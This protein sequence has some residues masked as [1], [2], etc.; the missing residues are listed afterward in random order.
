MVDFT[1]RNSVA[2]H[3]AAEDIHGAIGAHPFRVEAMERTLGD[4]WAPA[5][6]LVPLLA[7]RPAWAVPLPGRGPHLDSITFARA[8]ADLTSPP[9]D[10]I[11][12]TMLAP[13]LPSPTIETGGIIVWRVYVLVA[14]ALTRAA[15]KRARLSRFDLRDAAARRWCV[16]SPL[17]A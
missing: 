9:R 7:E 12:A 15:T 4:L 2:L 17:S 5:G 8:G 1:S 3:T 11:A 13:S 16:P 6:A 10:A 14:C